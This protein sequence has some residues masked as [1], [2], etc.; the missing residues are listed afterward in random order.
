[1]AIL[2]LQPP[3]SF[4]FRSLECWLK[5]KRRFQQ[6][7]DAFDLSKQFDARQVSTL[8]Y[9]LGEE[10]DDVP[11]LTRRTRNGSQRLC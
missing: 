5:G 11:A 4:D 6:Y 7:R 3:N 10:T 8:L 9:C 2:Q 1:M